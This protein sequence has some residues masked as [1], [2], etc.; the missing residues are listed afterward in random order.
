MHSLMA[1]TFAGAVEGF[2]TYPTE[3][4]KTQAQLASNA[5]SSSQAS[6]SLAD[7]KPKVKGPAGSVRYI[8]YGALPAHKDGRRAP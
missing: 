2:L 4:V 6:S 8:S 3:F 7:A 5:A 1:G